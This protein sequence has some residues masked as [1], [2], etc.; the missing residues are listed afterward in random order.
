M[1]I[2]FFSD[3]LWKHYLD[4]KWFF[5]CKVINNSRTQRLTLLESLIQRPSRGTKR[6][7]HRF[8][9]HVLWGFTYIV[10]TDYLEIHRILAFSSFETRRYIQDYQTWKGIQLFWRIAKKLKHSLK[11]PISNTFEKAIR[12]QK[13][14]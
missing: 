6:S 7:K 10:Y 8:N 12:Y 13:H 5:S 9:K 1:T 14:F 4:S 3:T 11:R 2:M